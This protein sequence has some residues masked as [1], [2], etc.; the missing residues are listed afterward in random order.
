[1]GNLETLD[2]KKNFLPG[3]IVTKPYW[4]FKGN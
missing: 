1:M 3:A 2:A 4:L